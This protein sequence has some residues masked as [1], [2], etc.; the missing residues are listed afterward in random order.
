MCQ[1]GPHAKHFSLIGIFM[2]LLVAER[3][4]TAGLLFPPKYLCRTI[5][6]TLYSTVWHLGDPVFDG[7]TQTGFERRDNVFFY[8]SY[9]YKLLVP[10]RLLL[11]PLL[12]YLLLWVGIVGRDL[13]HDWVSSTLSQHSIVYFFQ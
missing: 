1:C 4:S 6:V 11:F 3:F 10:V 13:R 5:L 9:I 7:V 8:F 2:R 12:S